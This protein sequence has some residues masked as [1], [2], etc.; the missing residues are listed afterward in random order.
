MK[1]KLL[2]FLVLTA[3][4]KVF[5][6]SGNQDLTVQEFQSKMTATPGAVLLDLRTPDET[7]KGII[8]SA[9]QLDYFK[10]DFE[11][12]VA[13]LDKSKTYF[14][15]CA[16]G[17]RSGETAALMTRLGFKNIYNLKDGFEAWKKA[18][19]PIEPVKK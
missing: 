18:K 10:K 2:F 9:K 4:V 6:Q 11:S 14:L 17:G 3:A 15:Y 13:R 16:A 19:M 5:A 1:T 12:E 7:A 8:P